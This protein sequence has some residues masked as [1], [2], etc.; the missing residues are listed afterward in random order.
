M[1]AIVGMN[2]PALADDDRKERG[3]HRER[4]ESKKGHDSDG[5]GHYEKGDKDP[6]DYHGEADRDGK[7]AKGEETGTELSLTEKYDKVR[8]GACLIM[9]YNAETKTFEGTVE[10]TT[11]ETL[12][13]VRV[14]VH[15]SNGKELGPT[16]PVSLRSG[17]KRKVKLKFKGEKAFEGW[18]VHAEVGSG[19]HQGEGRGEHSRE[20]GEHDDREAKGEHGDRELG[21][22][23]GEH[24]DGDSE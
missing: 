7:K 11:K 22:R 18:S 20:R 24:K 1:F 3:E 5:E 14:E 12:K 4:S 19:E 13:R 2:S 10:N 15:L 16:R 8:G 17:K 21:E 23:K 9:A 6:E